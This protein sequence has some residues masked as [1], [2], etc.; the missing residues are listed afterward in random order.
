MNRVLLV[1]SDVYTFENQLRSHND[2]IYVTFGKVG[3]KIEKKDL[4]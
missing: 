3:K 4:N 1:M 2:F